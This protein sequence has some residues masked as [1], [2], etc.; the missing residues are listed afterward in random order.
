MKKTGLVI[1][2]TSSLPKEIIEK[3]GMTIVPYCVDWRDGESLRGENIFQKII[4]AE[5]KG[6]KTLPKTSQPSPW[7]FKKIFEEELKKS[8]RIICVTL[9]SKLS[10]GYN[11]ACQGNRMLR[12]EEQDRIFILDS[13][14]ITV[15]E[16]LLAIRAAELIEEGKSFTDVKNE[17]NNFILKIHLFGMLEDPKWSEAGGRVS[18]TLAVLLKQMQKIGLRPLIGL[19]NGEVKPVALKMQANDVPTALLKELIKETI[20]KKVRIAIGH[21][22]NLEGAQKI[23]EIIEKELPEI[24]I[25]FLSLVDSIIG[26]HIGPGA[27]I[28]AWHELK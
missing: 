23:K 20:G 22:D 9:S 13:L 14:N 21:A 10:G 18:H 7:I 6:I 26:V 25:A 12:K 2:E 1:G 19:K 11:S 24:E 15:G 17:L 28:C 16:G 4:E 5:R 3:Y 27:L 8:E